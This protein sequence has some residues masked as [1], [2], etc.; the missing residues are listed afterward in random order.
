MD[1]V[2]IRPKIVSIVDRP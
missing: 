1:I 2:R